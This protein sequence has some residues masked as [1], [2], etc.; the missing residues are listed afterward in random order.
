MN[1]SKL[2]SNCVRKE[3]VD[4]SN[5]NN[6]C[7]I[8]RCVCSKCPIFDY[9]A[10]LIDSTLVYQDIKF[11]QFS[12][13]V[14]ECFIITEYDCN[15]KTLENYCYNP[16]KSTVRIVDK[17]P[18]EYGKTDGLIISDRLFINNGIYDSPFGRY[19][20]LDH[21][22]ML[23]INENKWTPQIIG[24]YSETRTA[25]ISLLHP[26]DS[27]KGIQ[28]GGITPYYTNNKTI[29]IYD[30]KNYRREIIKNL[31]YNS[32]YV[33]DNG[34]SQHNALYLFPKLRGDKVII[35]DPREPIS[36]DI[37]MDTSFMENKKNFNI[38]KSY[39]SIY[40]IGGKIQGVSTN[41]Y[42]SISNEII[43][44]DTRTN[45]MQFCTTMP[46]K[47][48]DFGSF[49]FKNEI[50]IVGGISANGI[51]DEKIHIYDIESKS[52]YIS[53]D[54]LPKPVSVNCAIFNERYF[55]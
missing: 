51:N 2:Y 48:R 11:E 24:N 41:R 40:L 20:F 49:C 16:S 34:S 1:F 31:P 18:Y 35:W 54:A 45:K 13:D 7:F 32:N 36:H 27:T 26:T 22:F 53:G 55:E 15:K 17:L 38:S 29:V 50:F 10:K 21:L 39:E 30:Y 3:N 47:R 33:I 9:D 43:E 19:T 5:K 44:Y 6:C 23:D 46:I 25:S 28:L 12:Y 14:P 42:D 8:G 52:W 37:T 4:N